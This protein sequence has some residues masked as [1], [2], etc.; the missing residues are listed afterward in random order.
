MPFYMK[1]TTNKKRKYITEYLYK[2]FS[3]NRSSNQ[4]ITLISEPIVS[5]VLFHFRQPDKVRVVW[6]RRNRRHSTKVTTQKRDYLIFL[7]KPSLGGV[8]VILED[9]LQK[10]VV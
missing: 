1:N 4:S 2:S 9:S 10:M 8:T 6:I 5:T 3:M 7:L